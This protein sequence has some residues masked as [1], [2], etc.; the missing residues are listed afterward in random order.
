MEI[1]KNLGFLFGILT[2]WVVGSG[3]GTGGGS[4]WVVRVP[5]DRVDQ[6]GSN[7]GGYNVAVAI[8]GELQ[9]WVA[10]MKNWSFFFE[11]RDTM[12]NGEWR[13]HGEWQ[14]LGG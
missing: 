4:G 8:L 11:D 10:Y 1:R 9:A 7:S 5:L 3:G 13:W 6:G 12:D 2:Q 14:W